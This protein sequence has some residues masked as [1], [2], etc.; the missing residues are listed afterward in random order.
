M[1]KS[2]A[3]RFAVF[4]KDKSMSRIGKQPIA[5]PSG[6][7]VKCEGEKI[8]FKKGTLTKELDTKGFVDFKIEGGQLLFAKKSDA[9]EHRAFW[10]TFRALADNVVIGL[11]TGFEKK[12]EINGVGYRAAVV[13]KVLEM[14]LGYSHPIKFD[15]P[16][17]ID[18]SVDKNVVT[19]KGADKQQVGQVAADIRSF[20]EPEPYK[21]KGV[22]YSDEKILRKAGKA[23]K[24]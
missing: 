16:T 13:G 5:I 15:I 10:G 14:Q 6:V 9:R 2:A 23:S 8:L 18:I 12:L 17:G 1:A 4:G 20:R 24:K 7:E 19:I 11:T 3:K 21:G 22:K